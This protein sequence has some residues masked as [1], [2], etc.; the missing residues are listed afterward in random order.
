M[1]SETDAKHPGATRSAGCRHPRSAREDPRERGLF[2]IAAA[3]ALPLVRRRT[4]P[5]RAGPFAQRIGSGPRA[6]R[7]GHGLRWRYR[8]GG[9]GRCQAAPRQTARVLPGP[10]RSRR[11]FA[12]EG[13]LRARLRSERRRSHRH[14]SSGCS[15]GAAAS[16]V[17]SRTSAAREWPSALWRVVAARSPA[18][19]AWRALR[20]PAD[21]PVQLLPLA[22]YPGVEGAPALSPDGKLVA[23]A[24][25]GDAETGPTDIY[26]KAV[27]SEA[28]RRLTETPD[29]ESS[30][31]WSPDGHSIAFVRDGQGV[32]TM[33]Q[34]GGAERQVSAVRHS[35]RLG[36]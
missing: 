15:P 27:G 3:A 5:R 30:P 11:H 8:S 24:W 28:L 6:V 34:L 35:R 1:P 26:V 20:R 36:W 2:S 7:E 16:A 10:I 22:S 17:R 29:S 9:S 13:Q 32:F 18:V 25:S 14:G 23:F 4:K 12:A 31:A 19:L 21:A 33:S